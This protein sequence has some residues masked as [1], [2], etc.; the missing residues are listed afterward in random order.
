MSS[1]R[2]RPRFKNTVHLSIQDIT[3]KFQKLDNDTKAQFMVKLSHH[4]I[5]IH[6][7]LEDRHYW[8]PVLTISLEET[9]DG[10]IVRG[11][12]G[13]NPSVW[14]IFFFGYIALGLIAL[15]AGMYGAS[16]AM[17]NMEAPI[18][19]ILPICGGLALLLYIIAQ[20]GQKIGAEQMFRMHHFYES[21]I[22]H[23]T[24]LK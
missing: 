22:D 18:L 16:K 2:I 7:P 20:G 5:T 3:Q 24:H 19:W 14:A 11:L 23:K 12:Y 9:P 1:F 21:I 10:T 8:S 17:L 4:H 6:I 15:F 13:P